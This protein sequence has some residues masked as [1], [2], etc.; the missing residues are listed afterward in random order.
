[1][2]QSILIFCMILC[3]V[4]FSNSISLDCNEFK[5]KFESFFSNKV[6]SKYPDLIINGLSIKEIGGGEIQGCDYVK[7]EFPKKYA[8]SNHLVVKFD[9]FNGDS[10]IKR[11]TKIFDI[12]ASIDVLRIKD[13]VSRGDKIQKESIYNDVIS[14]HQFKPYLISKI[15]N[16]ESYEFRNYI[17][18]NQMLESWMIDRIPDKKKGDKVKVSYQKDNIILTLDAYLL[19]NGSIGDT[20]KVKLE[21]NQKVM[22]GKIYDKET[23]IISNR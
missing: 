13:T 7:F 5:S 2:I 21:S 10:F 23:I 4:T 14:I 6:Y 1:M 15:D 11:V 18:K 19:E 8:L 12:S 9:L 3:H 16:I 20:V 22:A 17:E